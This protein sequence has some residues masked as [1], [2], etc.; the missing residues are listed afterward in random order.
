M[1]AADDI[2]DAFNQFKLQKAPYNLRYIIFEIKGHVIEMT[3][4]GERDKTW[5]DF[6][7]ELPDND[8]RYA[9]VDVE[10]NTDDGRP[11][12]KIVFLSW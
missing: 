1:S 6:C 12:S 5:A 4:K 8:G 9:V 11:T 2:T 10:F 7:T 3:S